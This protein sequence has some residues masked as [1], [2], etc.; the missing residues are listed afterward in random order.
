MLFSVKEGRY[1]RRKLFT[2]K[3]RAL[4]RDIAGLTRLCVVA[5]E[6]QIERRLKLWS[7]VNVRFRRMT[8]IL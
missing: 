6:F 1:Q 5:Y 4:C 3:E 2:Y 7:Y 8:F